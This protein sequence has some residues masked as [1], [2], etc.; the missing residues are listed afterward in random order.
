MGS[1]AWR[2]YIR[3]LICVHRADD[4]EDERIVTHSKCNY[5]PSQQSL[6]FGFRNVKVDTDLE[7]NSDVIA[8]QIVELGSSDVSDSEAVAAMD[9]RHLKK[10]ENTLD[11]CVAW[12]RSFFD[13]GEA[14]G[15]LREAIIAAAEKAEFNKRTVD[16]AAE[17]VKELVETIISDS[18]SFPALRP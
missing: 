15:V 12:L 16:R 6:R 7:D 10:A 4:N 2:A 5:G 13:G 17:D 14:K 8:S 9:N 3:S 11:K 1:R 18:W